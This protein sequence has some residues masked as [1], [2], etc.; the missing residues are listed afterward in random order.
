MRGYKTHP[1]VAKAICRKYSA[2]QTMQSIAAEHKCSLSLIHRLLD[3]SGIESRR[4]RGQ[5][6]DQER[7]SRILAMRSAGM[8]MIAIAR[9]IGVSKQRVH[10]ILE[11]HK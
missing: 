11:S 3:A 7:R 5:A 8:T 6:M 2:G 10:Q 9:E 1:E 4:K